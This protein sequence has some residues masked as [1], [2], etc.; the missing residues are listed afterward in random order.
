MVGMFQ[1]D[2]KHPVLLSL[3]KCLLYAHVIALHAR[4]QF[5]FLPLVC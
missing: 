3:Y 1:P 5:D 2:R 4:L